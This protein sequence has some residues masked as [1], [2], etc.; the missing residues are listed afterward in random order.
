MCTKIYTPKVVLEDI[1]DIYEGLMYSPEQADHEEANLLAA[2]IQ[3]ASSL[4]MTATKKLLS[5]K[6][7]EY[8]RAGNHTVAHAIRKVYW[9][10]YNCER[11]G[12]NIALSK[13]VDY[14]LGVY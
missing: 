3:Q 6:A 9:S 4:D 5:R 12:S 11:D 10:L 7:S 2:Y 8:S 14:W 1:M 13:A